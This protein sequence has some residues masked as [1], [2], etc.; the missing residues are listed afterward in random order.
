[1]NCDRYRVQAPVFAG[2]ENANLGAAC[3]GRG[4]MN[5]PN[6]K[7]ADCSSSY[8]LGHYISSALASAFR[9]RSGQHITDAR[10]P[11]G[12]CALP[13][14][15]DAGGESERHALFRVDRFRPSASA[16]ASTTLGTAGRMAFTREYSASV[17]SGMST[18][19]RMR[20]AFLPTDQVGLLRH[21][22]TVR[23]ADRRARS[24]VARD[25]RRRRHGADV[26]RCRSRPRWCATA[27]SG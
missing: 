11:A 21:A 9:Q 19:G 22:L 20:L 8:D 26:R 24:L 1:M 10:L 7:I 13:G 12:A 17:I 4:T 25:E 27:S 15:H 16:F 3:R 2:T 18:S 14:G 5:R 23:F 6:C